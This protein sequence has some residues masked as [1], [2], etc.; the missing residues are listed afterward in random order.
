MSNFIAGILNKLSPQQRLRLHRLRHPAWMGTLRRTSPL[1]GEWGFDRGTPIDRYYIEQ[2]LSEHQSDIQGR[3]LEIKNDDYTRRFGQGI[4][5]ADV[6]D[7]DAANPR[8]TLIADLTAADALASDQFDC[9]I[10]TQTLQF[11]YDARAAI[12]HAHRLLHPGGVLLVTVPSVS[13]LAPRYG[14]PTDY[15]RF[16]QAS[17]TALFGAVFGAEQVTVR[18]YGSVLT[19]I[20]FLTGMA[21]EELTHR[22]LDAHDDY[23]PL[24]IAVRAI[25]AATA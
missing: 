5:Q 12:N 10:L 11:I 15:W 14:L 23:F 1:S 18:A 13:R 22:E 21:H 25:K 9:F 7:I 6:L 17:C 24:I 16:T 20:A 8:A 2:F 3:V 4:T 19:N